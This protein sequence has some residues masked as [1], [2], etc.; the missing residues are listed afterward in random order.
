[1]TFLE[2][3]QRLRQEVGAAGSGP[4]SVSSQ[5]GEYARL[6]SWVQQAWREIQL[7]RHRWRFAWAEAS[8][9]TAPD[10]RT[11]SPPADLD[12]WDESTLMCAGN[13]LKAWPWGEFRK[14][15][16]FDSGQESPGA[17]TRK[18]DGTII[19][20]ASPAAENQPLTFEYWRTPQ[21]LTEGGD[22]PRLPERYHMVIVY[23]AMLYY[24]LYEN[25]PEVAQAARNG[26]STILTEMEKLE[27]PAMDIF[28][29]PVA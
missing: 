15:Y 27:L 4:A 5:H 20:D 26:E 14:R 19:L 21:V 18:P 9:E 28:G 11:Y 3:C 10:F 12:E 29:G 8:I 17:I 24:A 13:Q 7:E 16:A 1:V 23:R 25:A 6:V 22:V 2:L